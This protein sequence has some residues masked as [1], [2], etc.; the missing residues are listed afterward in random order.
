RETARRRNIT[1]IHAGAFAGKEYRTFCGK[2]ALQRWGL[3]TS[4]RMALRMPS[5]NCGISGK[6]GT[7]ALR[8]PRSACLIDGHGSDFIRRSAFRLE[9]ALCR[10]TF[11]PHETH[12]CQAL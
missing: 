3:S 12:R 10:Q 4:E 5:R 7:R 1:S 6:I 8:K 2:N 11:R 9:L